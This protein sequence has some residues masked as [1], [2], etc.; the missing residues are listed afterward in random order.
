MTERPHR[1]ARN[2]IVGGHGAIRL[3]SQDLAVEAVTRLGQARLARVA[4]RRVELAVGSELQPAA[5]V[6]RAA[7]DAVQEHALLSRA[8]V[9]QREPYDAID[10]V[11][12]PRGRVAD[13]EMAGVAEAGIE[14]QAH[15]AGL[16]LGG[17]AQRGDGRGLEPPVLHDADA[18]DAFGHE[19]TAI[20]CERQRPGH[21]ETGGDG[22]DP[23]LGGGRQDRQ[24]H[25]H[26]RAGEPAQKKS[27]AAMKTTTKAPTPT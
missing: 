14:G 13:I 17:D 8:A 1:R 12:L 27:I 10:Q 9:A 6:N 23:G 25:E 24:R 16:A 19:Q 4:H 7:A 20:G 5:V 15:E 21:L 18:S 26:Q 11:T 22:L 3:E 2:R